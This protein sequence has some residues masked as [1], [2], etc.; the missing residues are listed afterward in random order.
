MLIIRTLEG[1]KQVVAPDVDIHEYAAS[2]GGTVMNDWEFVEPPRSPDDL[3]IDERA[4]RDAEIERVR[5]L[6]DRHRDEMDMG[7]P[8]SLSAEQFA[9]LLLYIQQLRTWPQATGF[10]DQAARPVPPD[11]LAVPAQ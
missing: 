5:W 10:P 11:W 9:G 8:T 7:V 2:T 1:Y 6:R 3:A 4:W